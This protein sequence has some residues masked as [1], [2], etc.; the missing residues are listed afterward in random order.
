[1]APA[2]AQNKRKVNELDAQ[3]EENVERNAKIKVTKENSSKC[4]FLETPFKN[5]IM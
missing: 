3:S 4:P 5:I 1:M 2:K